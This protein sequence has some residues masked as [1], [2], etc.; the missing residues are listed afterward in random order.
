MKTM[1]QTGLV[2]VGLLLSGAA[3]AEQRTI[4]FE[5]PGLA[6]KPLMWVQDEKGVRIETVKWHDF[7]APG[8]NA[9]VE[10]WDAP[11]SR[12]F[13][14]SIGNVKKLPFFYRLKKEGV[15]VTFTGGIETMTAAVGTVNFIKATTMP[16]KDCVFFQM[17]YKKQQFSHVTKLLQGW[18]CAAAA[19]PLPDE[20]I[21]AAIE[22][23]GVAGWKGPGSGGSN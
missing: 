14:E 22:S 6:G 16:P 21:R 1:I 11:A 17:R 20:T 15:K 4:L 13:L 8:A 2:T 10:Y 18:Y 7:D 5:A 3:G 19:E 23:L 9:M 12:G